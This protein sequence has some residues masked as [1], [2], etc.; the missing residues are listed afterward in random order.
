MRALIE[1]L[2]DRRARQRQAEIVLAANLAI[3]EI[4]RR[5]I[6]QLLDT[7]RRAPVTANDEVIDSTAVEVDPV[8][9]K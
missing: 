2:R 7:E 6:R 9:G 8:D 4:K 1:R 3:R 5:T